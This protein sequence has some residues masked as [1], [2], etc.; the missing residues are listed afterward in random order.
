MTKRYREAV[1]VETAA[2]RDSDGGAPTR[3][4]WREGR[5]QVVTVL[6]HWREDAGYWAGGGVE[7][8]QRDLWRVEARRGVSSHGIY[9][10]VCEDLTSPVDDGDAGVGVTWRLDR[11][12]D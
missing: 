4:T 2:G 12:W 11:V 7:V 8:P 9:E 1:E 10:L 6:G 3:F 5:Y